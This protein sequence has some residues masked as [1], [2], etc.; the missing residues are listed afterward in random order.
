M[1]VFFHP[2]QVYVQK[3]QEEYVAQVRYVLRY[4][5]QMSLRKLRLG[6]GPHSHKLTKTSRS[7][8]MV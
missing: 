2:R 4:L 8:Y 1:R 5:N 7:T 6:G 3:P